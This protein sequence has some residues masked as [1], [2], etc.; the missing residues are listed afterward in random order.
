MKPLWIA[1]GS[2]TTVFT[3][4]LATFLVI[5]VI[6][7]EE[8]TEIDTFAASDVTALDLHG[9]N[10]TIEVVGRDVGEIRVVSHIDHGLRRTA[11]TTEIRDGTLVV[12]N[13]CP[14]GPPVHC[15]VDYEIVVP[16]DLPVALESD[17]GT[18]HARDLRAGLVARTDNGSIEVVRISGRTELRSRNGSVVGRGLRSPETEARTSNGRVEL[19][20]SD[21]PQTVGAHSANGSI[22]VIVPDDDTTYQ[23]HADTANG[24]TDTPVRLDPGADRVITAETRNGSVTVR[25]PTG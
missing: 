2:V 23:V 10:S 25:Y 17:N 3:L 21:A 14:S 24:S 6:A 13:D 4:A 12:D 15:R 9:E 22:E 7:H 20:F 19:S 1:I 18:V 16:H 8:V 11:T 5:S